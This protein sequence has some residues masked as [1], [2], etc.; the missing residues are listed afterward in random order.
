MK[1]ERPVRSDWNH[2]T[3]IETRW[4]DNDIYGHVNNVV[5]YTFFD[6][7]VAHWMIG[8]DLFDPLTSQVI[9]LV[10]DSGCTYY[11]SVSHPAVLEIGLKAARIG[12]TSIKYS[13]GV[14]REESN[15]AIALGHF[16]H[17]AVARDSKK[18]VPLS[19]E[20]R[21]ALLTL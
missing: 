2:F 10:V 9:Y 12:R 7:A 8:R 1:P 17:V 4:I 20:F 18:P 21:A 15:L 16:V 13:I 11:E 19:A 5:Y 6:T 3:A 14:F